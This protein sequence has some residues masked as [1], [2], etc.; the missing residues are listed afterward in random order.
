MSHG[1]GGGRLG[2]ERGGDCG[3]YL[4]LKGRCGGS[5]RHLKRN[6]GGLELEQA[7]VVTAAAATEN[8]VNENSKQSNLSNSCKQC[9]NEEMKR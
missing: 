1:R 3:C 2:G 5:F 4:C 9:T 6:N 7:A 8:E